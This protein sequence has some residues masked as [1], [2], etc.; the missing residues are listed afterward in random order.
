M[1][2]EE[3]KESIE[4][5]LNAKIP[6]ESNEEAPAATPVDVPAPD[7][8]SFILSL[9]SAALMDLGEIEHPVTKVK[10]QKLDMAKHS[11]DLLSV[12]KEK[13]EGNLSEE[14]AKLVDNMLADLRLRYCN[15]TK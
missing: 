15:A 2:D 13:T 14:E 7:F 5:T 10:E 3:V 12:L 4:E 8:S 11:I 6:A 9:C 1:T